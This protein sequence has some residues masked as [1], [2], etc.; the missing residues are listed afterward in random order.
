MSAAMARLLARPST[1]RSSMILRS[2]RSSSRLGARLARRYG[3]VADDGRR[4][5]PGGLARRARLLASGAAGRELDRFELPM[6][7][8]GVRYRSTV[9]A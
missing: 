3:S 2:A 5:L 1:L 6:S 9:M 8:V 4:L 7:G